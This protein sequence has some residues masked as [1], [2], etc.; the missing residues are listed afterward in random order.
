[1]ADLE[2]GLWAGDKKA[3]AAPSI[4]YRWVTAMAKGKPGAFALKGADAQAGGLQSLY[5]GARPAGYETM[6]K[7]GSIILGIGGDNSC[8]AVGTFYEGAMTARFTTDAT[9][10]AIQQNIVA[11]GCGR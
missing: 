5:A 2:N 6:K 10:E 8:G 1:M 7:Q 4:D 9:D 3:A 11:A